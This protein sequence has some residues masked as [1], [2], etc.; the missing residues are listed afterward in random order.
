M[1]NALSNSV[2]ILLSPTG[3]SGSLDHI[4]HWKLGSRGR[5]PIKQDIGLITISASQIQ[6]GF[7]T[8]KASHA[9]RQAIMP[10]P[11]LNSP[12]K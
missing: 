4:A 8:I 9:L 2:S 5:F 11:T 3:L 6:D 12:D 7:E 10:T 1:T